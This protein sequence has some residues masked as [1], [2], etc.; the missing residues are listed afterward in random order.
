M[1]G[2]AKTLI[3]G[4]KIFLELRVLLNMVVINMRFSLMRLPGWGAFCEEKKVQ[5]FWTMEERKWHINRELN[6]TFFAL[7]SFAKDFRNCEILR[8]LITSQRSHILTRWEGGGECD[9]QI[10]IRLQRR[11]GSSVKRRISG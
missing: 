6:A 4:K 7:K 9:T 11:F 2:N 3:N 1:S 5:D 10:C 8:A